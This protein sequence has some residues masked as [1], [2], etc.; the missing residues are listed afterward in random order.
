M[1]LTIFLSK[2]SGFKCLLSSVITW[3]CA[4]HLHMSKFISV[5]VSVSL[6]NIHFSH[7]RLF[8]IPL[9]QVAVATVYVYFL[10]SLRRSGV[11]VMEQLLLFHCKL[12]TFKSLGSNLYFFFIAFCCFWR[13]NW[14]EEEKR[15]LK[16][17]RQKLH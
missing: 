9:Q 14:L 16:R 1:R 15:K 11:M 12:S 6:A 8:F 3:V 13:K 2:I 7:C 10:T 17:K 4:W 5:W